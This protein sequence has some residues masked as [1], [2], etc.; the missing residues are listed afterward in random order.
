MS[1]HELAI[2]PRAD[3]YSQWYL[4]TIQAAQLADYS[5]VKGCMVIRPMGYAIWEAIQKDLDRRFK[6]TGHTNAYFPLFIPQS[7]LSREA[8][9]VEGFAKE[10]ALVTHHRL[11]STT[12]DGKAAVEPDPDSRLEE[13]LVV[14]PTSETIIWHMYRRWID[15]HRDL[16]L[17]IN[18]WANVV[19][20]EMKTRPF[21]RTAEFLWQE[22]HT[23]HANSR[24]AIEETLRMLQVYSDFAHELLA[25]PVVSGRKSSSERFAGAVDTY[26]I[27]AMM[28]NGWALQAG[29]SHFLGQNFARAFDV[30]FQDTDGRRRLV[31]ATSWGVSTRLIGA[32]IMAHSDDKGL[33]APPAVA[34]FQV[35]ITPIWKG[36][37]KKLQVL[38]YCERLKAELSSAF[39]VHLDDRDNI[40]PGAK[41][42]E[43]ERKGVPLRLEVGPRDMARENVFVARRIDAK[44]FPLSIHGIRSSIRQELDS[45]QL[46]MLQMATEK[47]ESN[48]HRLADYDT[49]KNQVAQQSGWYL[50][51][52]Y[53]DAREEAAIKAETR[54]TLRCFPLEGQEEAKGLSCF[55]TG[56]PATHMAIFARAY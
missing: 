43:W 45:I 13:P 55:K 36:A 15:S 51:P 44:K 16:P 32:M 33:V 20:W 12:V 17:L 56:R 14:R 6:E 28:Q 52:W 25:L 8:E 34:P 48:T 11:R 35:V 21:L 30:T 54:A 5:P 26:C 3:D 46:K 4:D 47:R 53:D 42:Y 41:Y 31:W 27:E 24:E 1:T 49:F 39:R 29:T 7:F 2:T 37:S 22:G 18:Q 23:A 40:K 9:H 38:E 19:R 10:C 50:V